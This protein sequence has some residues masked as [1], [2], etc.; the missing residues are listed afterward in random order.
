VGCVDTI[1]HDRYPRQ[2]GWV[3]QR[4]AVCFFYNTEHTILGKVVRDDDED[5]YE[6]VIRLDDG[7][8]VRGTECQFR[9]L[10]PAKAGKRSKTK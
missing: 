3:G 9:P 6:T 4:V 10:N 8:F 5:P 7:R 1:R 2:T